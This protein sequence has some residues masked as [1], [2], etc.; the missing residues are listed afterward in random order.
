LSL[1]DERALWLLIEPF[2]EQN[3]ASEVYVFGAFLI[4]KGAE[5]IPQLEQAQSQHR[6]HG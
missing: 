6:F 2:T 3:F 5:M 1:S 4:S